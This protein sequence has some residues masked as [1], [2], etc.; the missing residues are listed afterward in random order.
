MTCPSCGHIN[1]QGALYC[2]QCWAVLQTTR[3]DPRRTT[4]TVSAVRVDDPVTDGRQTTRTAHLGKLAPYAIAIYVEDRD[5]PLIVSL[6]SQVALGRATESD[7][8][9]R[10]DLSPFGAREK[11]VSR[12]HCTLKRIGGGM[13]IQDMGSS[14]GTWMDGVRLQPYQPTLIVSGAR[15]QLGRLELQVYLPA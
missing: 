9:T 10:I 4:L 6:I 7:V 1:P 14:N 8:Q 5:E 15:L 2:D 13:M 3:S 11:G 12:Q